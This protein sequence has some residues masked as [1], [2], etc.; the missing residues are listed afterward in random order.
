VLNI[1]LPDNQ[2]RR[3]SFYLAME[4]YVARK[5]GGRDCFF[6][7]QVEPSVIFGRNQVMEN[8]V[9]IDYCIGHNIKMYRRKSGGGCV[10]AD[11][12]NLMFSLVSQ[13]ENVGFAFNRYMQ[14]MILLFRKLG[15]EAV[16]SKN[17]DIMIAGHKVCGT[18]CYKTGRHCIVHGTMLY[19]TDIENMSHAITP[20]TAKLEKNG[21]KSVRQRICLLKDFTDVGID[22]IK[23]LAV[24]LFCNE[25]YVLTDDD[26]E[27]IEK[28]GA[29]AF[30]IGMIEN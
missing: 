8:E 11:M 12:N 5:F 1:S 7:W 25:E 30:S 3:L 18:A 19:D 9:N 22:E 24:N 16:S 27:A 4:E 17:N 29:A 15:V 26:I 20:T 6:I 28:K 10:Y 23:D 2:N 13:C 14:M 21:V